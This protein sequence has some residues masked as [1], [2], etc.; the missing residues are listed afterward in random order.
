VCP[1]TPPKPQPHHAPIPATHPARGAAPLLLLQPQ[2]RDALGGRLPRRRRL[3]RRLGRR[4]QPPR[5][6]LAG[7]GGQAREG[8]AGG[9]LQ[10]GEVLF[11]GWG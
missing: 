2:P 7:Q 11:W 5:A 8:G 9:G 4:H 6:R 1:Q 3:G 10:L